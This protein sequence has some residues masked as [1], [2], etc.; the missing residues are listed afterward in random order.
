[1]RVRTGF[2]LRA[3]VGPALLF[4]PSASS[5][6]EETWGIKSGVNVLIQA[7]LLSTVSLDLLSVDTISKS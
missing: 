1:M 5:S 7:V 4:L 6:S 2:T 3:K